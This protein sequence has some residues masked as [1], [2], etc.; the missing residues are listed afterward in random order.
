[1]TT[2]VSDIPSLFS[3]EEALYLS[4]DTPKDLADAL[5]WLLNNRGHAAEMASRGSARIQAACAQ[6]QV[7]QDLKSFFFPS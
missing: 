2:R 1:L 6:A 5:L 4:A 3:D 7:G